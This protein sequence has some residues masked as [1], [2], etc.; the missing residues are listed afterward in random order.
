MCPPWPWS[1]GSLIWRLSGNRFVRHNTAR[2]TLQ[3]RPRPRID[4]SCASTSSFSHHSFPH[5]DATGTSQ[6]RGGRFCQDKQTVSQCVK[7][8]FS[9]GEKTGLAALGSGHLP[10]GQAL[11]LPWKQQLTQLH[12]RPPPLS[13]PRQSI[14]TSLFYNHDLMVIRLSFLQRGGSFLECVLSSAA[15]QKSQLTY[16]P[17]YRNS[18]LSFK[19]Q[20]ISLSVMVSNTALCVKDYWPMT[21]CPRWHVC[22]QC[23]QLRMAALFNT[24]NDFQ[25]WVIFKCT[26]T[27]WCT[28]ACG[29]FWR[30][31]SGSCLD[32][33]IPGLYLQGM[34]SYFSCK[35]KEMFLAFLVYQEN[36]QPFLW[37]CKILSDQGFQGCWI[38]IDKFSILH[39]LIKDLAI[40][41]DMTKTHNFKY[42][43]TTLSSPTQS[44]LLLVSGSVPW[45][46]RSQEFNWY[47]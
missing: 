44:T 45:C 39:F 7:G 2:P 33:E 43:L 19:T 46:L 21:H 22:Y 5:P 32:V 16:Q 1:L 14:L 18:Y 29:C 28:D 9:R 4:D 6:L 40:I 17:F 24:K 23:Y 41:M 26:L 31:F 37:L 36:S 30:I 27:C 38:K 20:W 42:N 11:D 3:H 15:N 10:T 34:G 13:R 35:W 47:Q 25:S 12:A 8:N